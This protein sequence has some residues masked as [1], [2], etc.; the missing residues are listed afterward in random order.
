MTI[1][2]EIFYSLLCL[3]FLIS[4]APPQTGG[5]GVTSLSE[6]QALNQPKISE[7]QRVNA[8]DIGCGGIRLQALQD[9]ALSLGA[10]A[11]LAL[12]AKQIDDELAK[13]DRQLTK[14]FNFN[15]LLLAHNVLP[16]VLL[17]SRSDLNANDP[18]TIR[19]ADRVYRIK[20]QAHFVTT[21]PTWREY[22]W[23]NYTPPE[24]PVGALLPKNALEKRIWKKYVTQGWNEGAAQADTIFSENLARLKEDYSGMILYLRLLRQ[25]MVSP[26]YV[27]RSELGVTGDADNLRVNDQVLRITALPT[28][29]T[30]SRMWVP[31]QANTKGCP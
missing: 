17:Q 29:Q 2:K 7:K 22:L 20:T 13:Q 19:L 11:G 26:P 21:S 10:Q 30:D 4:C 3:F 24:C 6:L 18:T 31:L 16:P 14:T 27:A 8:A 23:L 1:M 25:G 15:L 5:G 12:R 28:M 9:S